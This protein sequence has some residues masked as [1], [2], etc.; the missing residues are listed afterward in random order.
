MSPDALDR[1]L[2]RYGAAVHELLAR[3]TRV[4][5]EANSCARTSRR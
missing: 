4:S 3:R 2:G 1:L 5:I